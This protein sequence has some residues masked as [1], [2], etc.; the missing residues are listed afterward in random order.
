METRWKVAPG[1]TVDFVKYFQGE[2]AKTNCGE[3][4]MVSGCGLERQKLMESLNKQLSTLQETSRQLH[5]D[6]A[7]VKNDHSLM[8]E[9]LD[10]LKSDMKVHL[11]HLVSLDQ[12]M[13]KLGLE[14]V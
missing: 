2:P 4:M 5:E 14:Q 8:K 11:D 6:Q 12:H 7:H 13:A 3:N 1:L 9:K 10:V